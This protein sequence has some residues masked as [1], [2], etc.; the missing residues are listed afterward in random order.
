LLCRA[1]LGEGRETTTLVE[2]LGVLHP[3]QETLTAQMP[4]DNLPY[5]T[6]ERSS[7]RAVAPPQDQLVEGEMGIFCKP[8]LKLTRN[9]LDVLLDNRGRLF[10]LTLRR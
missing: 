9:Q 3:G 7:A 4:G 2:L 5:P 10:A 8:L 6:P 1:D